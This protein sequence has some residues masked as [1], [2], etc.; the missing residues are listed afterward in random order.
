MSFIKGADRKQI[1]LVPDCLDDFVSTENSVRVIDA[2]VDS[3]N[4]AALGFKSEP[5]AEGRPGYDPRD[6]LKLYI[7]GYL[8]KIRSSRRLQTEAGRN[9]E[10]MWLLGKIVPDFRCIADFRKDNAVAIKK[11]FREFVALCNKAGLLSHETVV[12]DGSKFRAVNADNNCY[13][14]ANV[15]KLIAQADE[16]IAK[17]IEE[18]DVADSADRRAE[19]LSADDI[20]NVLEYLEKRKAQLESALAEL[21]E[22]GLN[23][24]CTIDPESRLM[25]TRDGCKPSFNVQTA[26]E[27]NNHIIT[28]FDVTSECTDWGL[29]EAGISGAKEAVGA[30]TL[31]GVADKGYCS[32]EIILKCLLNGDTPTIYPNKN[33]NCR[34]FKFDKTDIEITPKMLASKDHEIL[35]KC[36]ASGVLPEVLRRD[37]VTLEIVTVTPPTAGQFL[38]KE[39]GEIVLF[40]EMK[41]AGGCDRDKV[42]AHCAPPLFPYFER[43]IK[44]DTV[45]CPMGQTLFYAGPGQPNGKRDAGIRRYHRLSVCQKCPNKCTRAKRRIISFKSGETQIYEHFYDD[46]MAGRLTQKANNTF[47]RL[48]TESLKKQVAVLRYY[49]N[50]HRLR[51]RNQIVEHPY[52]TV[53]RWSDGYYLLTKGR[54]KAAAEMA[55]SFLAYNMKRAVNVLGTEQLLAWV[56]A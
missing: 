25:K 44:A 8:N 16:R 31:E 39:T 43:D 47:V 22:S 52:G 53:K 7:Y 30:Q 20:Q 27:P 42:E 4:T 49:P 38:N 14:K 5:A 50:Q 40:E 45:T 18:L 2:F 17:Y 29:L 35:K 34:I 28:H 26:V 55:L 21:D 12:I 24:V 3:L 6:M 36:V 9:V 13:V 48:K 15:E 33:Q 32:D 41:A 23:H 10:L 51:S 1:T 56:N 54:V 37:D 46:C 19:E 11:V